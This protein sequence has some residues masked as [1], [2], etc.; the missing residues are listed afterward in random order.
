M[1]RI[2]W[3]LCARRWRVDLRWM[4][5]RRRRADLK[6]APGRFQA[7]PGSA[8]AGFT[9]VV[10]YA[11]TDDALRNLIALA[12]ELV[13]ERGGRVITLFGCGGDRDR[14]EASAHGP[15]GGGGKRSGGADQRQPAQ[16]RSDGRLLRRRWPAFARRRR[17]ASSSRTARLP[18]GLRFV[19][20][21]REILCCSQARGTRRCR[22]CATA[23]F[24]STMW[25]SRK[26]F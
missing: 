23:R 20:R 3:R 16:R 26:R 10:D 1:F 22:S 9:V 14:S 12:R 6:Q 17:S 5:L 4:R 21:A 7:V 19:P 8:E 11:H 2:C 25:W 15:R 18:L 24:R 13:K